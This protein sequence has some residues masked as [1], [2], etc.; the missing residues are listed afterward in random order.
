M[1]TIDFITKFPK[2]TTQHDSIMVLVDKLTKDAHFILVK[3][4]NKESNV[5]EIYMKQIV[6]LHGIPKATVLDKDSKFTSNFWKW[7]FKWFGTNLNFSIAYN[8]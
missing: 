6:R 8:P 4:I 5:A 7:L 2:T 3:S 1:V